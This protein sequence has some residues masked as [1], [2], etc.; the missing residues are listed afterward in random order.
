MIE[1]APSSYQPYSPGDVIGVYPADE[2]GSIPLYYEDID[3]LPMRYA[4]C[5]FQPTDLPDT[6][7]RNLPS[8]ILD[9]DYFIPSGSL[10]ATLHPRMVS[11]LPVSAIGIYFARSINL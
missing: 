7:N 2:P 3:Q 9:D 4:W 10:Q 5:N 1:L 8:T 11:L 6:G